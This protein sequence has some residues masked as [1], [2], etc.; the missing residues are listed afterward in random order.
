MENRISSRLYIIAFLLIVAL[1]ASIGGV[2]LASDISSANYY[3]VIL[4]SNNGTAANKVSTNMTL[5]TQELIDQGWIDDDCT[6]LAVRNGAGADVAFQ[7][8]VN[9]SYPWCLWVPSIG[10]NASLN[11]ILYTG[12]ASMD[13]SLCYFPG[14]AGM[15][16]SDNGS[17]KLSDNFSV[18][19][20]GYIDTTEVGA[21]ITLKE[22]AFSTYISGSGNITAEFY[23]WISPT[24]F[25]DP[26]TQ[27]T[28]ETKIYDDNTGTYGYDSIPVNNWSSFVEVEISV[29]QCRKVRYYADYSTA[30]I[31]KIDV[32][33]YYNGDWHDVYEGAFADMAWEEQPLNDTYSVNKSRVRFYNDYDSAAVEAKLYEFDFEESIMVTATGIDSGEYKLEIYADTDNLTIEVDDVV[34]DTTALDG[35][36]VT[37]NDKDWTFCEAAAVP[38]MEYAEITVN[39][40]QVGYW[41]WEYSTS[42]TDQSGH[43]NTATPT[44]RTVS[45]DEDVNAALVSFIPIKTATAPAYTVS[46]APDFISGN[47]T[48]SSNAT[49]GAISPSG[50]PGIALVEES[51]EA[52][53]T[54]NIWLWGIMGMFIIA[55]SGITLSYMEKQYGGGGGTLL[56]R[57]GI[58]AVIMGIFKAFGIFDWWMIVFY[59]FITVSIAVGSRHVEWGGLSSQHNL[60]G[61]LAMS[62]VGLTTINRMVEGQFITG[63]ETSFLN[64]LMFTQEF[65]LFGLFKIP[66]MNFRFFTEGIP[67]LLRW[68]YSFFGGNAQ[69]IQYMLYSITAVVSF[70]IFGL[71]IGLLYNYFNRLR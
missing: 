7:P 52:G 67:R 26:D 3:G 24:S 42:F 32:D 62:W 51:A 25:T 64:S 57:I 11:Y 65:E 40:E 31:N 55:I 60:I 4:V 34:E 22:D 23:K 36:S 54:P 50:P 66:V 1:L 45:S 69:L 10:N 47:L 68:D 63:E 6:Y 38:Y 27:W 46:D 15:S 16:V 29:I 17:L 5:S 21:N 56:L 48:T 33:A 39:G 41:E 58:A 2:A 9:D 28:D 61:F 44:F 71:I 19:I 59:L 49:T 13:A 12:N 18:E 8:S 70:I 14:P 37:D 53:G 30:D 35:A 43:G 20:S